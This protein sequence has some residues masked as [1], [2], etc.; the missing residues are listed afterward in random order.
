MDKKIKYY[1]VCAEYAYDDLAEEVQ[2]LIRTG[3]QPFGSLQIV[4]GKDN[5]LYVQPI[6]MY[7]D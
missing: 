5:L 3:W 4:K 2:N 1:G 7:E 6:V